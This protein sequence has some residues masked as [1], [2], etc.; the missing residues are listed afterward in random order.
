VVPDTEIER[1]DWNGSDLKRPL[2]AIGALATLVGVGFISQLASCN[3]HELG[4]GIV[5]TALG[6]KV[7]RINLCLPGSGSVEYSH[8]GTWAGNAQGYAGGVAAALF[9][10]ALFA[11]VFSR[12]RLPLRNSLWWAAGLATVVFIGPQLV[13]AVVEGGAG[14]GE[15]Y[16]ERFAESPEVFVPLLVGSA[17]LVAAAYTWRWRSVW[18]RNEAGSPRVRRTG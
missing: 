7:E 14:P 9:L 4:H 5:A 18:R 13:I 16:T 17:L 1:A 6:W 2:T 3:V 15:D 11:F 12:Q 10:F 8:V